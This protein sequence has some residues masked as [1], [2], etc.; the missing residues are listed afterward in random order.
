VPTI[1]NVIAI[2][3]LFTDFGNWTLRHWKKTHWPES[4]HRTLFASLNLKSDPFRKS[5][6]DLICSRNDFQML[7][8]EVAAPHLTRHGRRYK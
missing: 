8:E 6:L 4:L 2:A 7:R 1:K 5:Q 3:I